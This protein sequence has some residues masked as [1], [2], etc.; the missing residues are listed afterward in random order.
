MKSLILNGVRG[1]LEVLERPAAEKIPA[2]AP[3]PATAMTLA[4]TTKTFP[5]PYQVALNAAPAAFVQG[6]EGWRADPVLV[7]KGAW[8]P[9]WNVN[10]LTVRARCRK[11]AI[12]LGI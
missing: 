8:R 5:A 6:R 10:V 3:A 1:E 11:R 2:Y 4:V 9:R 7:T 12:I